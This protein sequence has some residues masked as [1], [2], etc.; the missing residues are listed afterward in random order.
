MVY[1][2]SVHCKPFVTGSLGRQAFADSLLLALSLLLVWGR[3]SV[4][5][6][7]LKEGVHL[8]TLVHGSELSLVFTPVKDAFHVCVSA[9]KDLA[10]WGKNTGWALVQP[11]ACGFVDVVLAHTGAIKVAADVQQGQVSLSSPS[12]G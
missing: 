10:V 6:E 1:T 5:G 11:G 8:F 4:Q 3:S 9:F 7:V 12:G 2:L